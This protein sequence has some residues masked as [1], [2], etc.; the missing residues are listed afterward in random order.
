[1]WIQ[2]RGDKSLESQTPIWFTASV[3][4]DGCGGVHL[5]KLTSLQ[6]R[7]GK[8]ILPDL[9]LSTERGGGGGLGILNLLQQLTNN[10]GIFMH[11]NRNN[12]SRNYKAQLFISHQSQ[13]TQ[14][15]GIISTCQGQGQTPSTGLRHPS[16]NHCRI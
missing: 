1:M 13:A 8:L 5:T 4:W 11:K 10:K 9:S 14:T 12:S 7:A 2:R 3:V 6:R 16:F 15:P